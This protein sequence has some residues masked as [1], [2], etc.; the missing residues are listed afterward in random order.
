M[1]SRVP[2]N[3][4]AQLYHRA[5]EKL[6]T[7]DCKGAGQDERGITQRFLRPDGRKS[8]PE[9]RLEGVEHQGMQQIDRIG[10]VSEKR[11]QA[12]KPRADIQA[13]EPY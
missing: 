8:P 9:H 2:T 13:D 10:S 1:I 6:P 5:L 11:A 4:L 12:T 3:A 7:R